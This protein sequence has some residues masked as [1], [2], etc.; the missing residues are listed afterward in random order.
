MEKTQDEVMAQ[1]EQDY[2]RAREKGTPHPQISD[3]HSDLPAEDGE[4]DWGL[5]NPNHASMSEEGSDAERE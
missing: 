3:Y 4:D 5:S 2:K 1:L